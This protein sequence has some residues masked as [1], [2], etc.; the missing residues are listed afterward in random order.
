MSRRL[1][2]MPDFDMT[3]AMWDALNIPVKMAF[4]HTSVPSGRLFAYYPSPAG[5]TESLLTLEGW[6]DLVG[7]NPLLGTLEPDVEA[8]LIHRVGEARDYFI[9]PIDRCY[10]LVGLLRVYWRGL[11][12]GTDVW[13][14]VSEYFD[15]LRAHARVRTTPIAVPGDA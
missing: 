10:E 3:D 11:S 8:L 2:Y 13:Q 1:I 9:V 4:L 6:A 14:R 5:A 12:G 7:R 15:G